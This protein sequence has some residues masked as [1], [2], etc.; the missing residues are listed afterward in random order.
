MSQA[1][2]DMI[3]TSIDL[4]QSLG[5]VAVLMGGWAAE[6]PISLKSGQAVTLALKAQGIDATACDV[7]CLE[8]VIK[9]TETFD[10]AFITLHGRWGEDGT[11][12]AL[13]DSL[14]FPYTGSG[15]AASAIAMD[16][17][18]TKW[19]WRGAGLPTPNFV[20][21][22]PTQPLNLTHFEL[23]FPVI[24][25]PIHEGSSIGMRK[26]N[27]LEALAEAVSYAQQFDSEILIEQWV[28]GR[29][30]TG[31]VLLGQALPL[32]E[33]KTTHDFY[34]YEAKYFANDTQ[35][36]CPA[37]L[38]DEL[39]KTL[40]D[41]IIKAFEVVGAKDWGRVDFMLDQNMNPW[42]IEINTVPGMT[43]HSLVPMA[44][45]AA[46][47]SFEALVL[48][49]ISATLLPATTTSAKV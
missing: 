6:R 42:L 29:E 12:Q 49:L 47:I 35:Y 37:S 48:K 31:A 33:L 2:N 45:K 3:E 10:R 20:L 24:V 14:K 11:V 5:K 25:K 21:V 32:I 1:L 8:D 36:L 40:P 46:N 19:M 34:D 43:D 18:R 23:E 30:F 39:V 27:G 26:V 44:A 38:P 4:K 22:S 15:M 41:M 17:L 7:Q 28:T 16:K 13:L 9:V